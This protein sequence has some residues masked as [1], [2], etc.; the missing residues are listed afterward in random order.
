MPTEQGYLRAT[1]P[2]GIGLGMKAAVGGVVILGLAGGAH[3]KARHRS[4]GSIVGNAA[5]D[6][7]ARAAVGAVEEGIPVTTVGRVK[8][9]AHAVGASGCIRR[10]AGTDAP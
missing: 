1:L 5:G 10:D 9:F 6:G 2:T 4:L 3:V 8:E 7:V